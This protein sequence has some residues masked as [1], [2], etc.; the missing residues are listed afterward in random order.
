MSYAPEHFVHLSFQIVV[1]KID[2]RKPE[3]FVQYQDGHIDPEICALLEGDGK[4]FLEWV[5]DLVYN[6]VDRSL[7][8][9][10]VESGI[11]ATLADNF[12]TKIQENRDIINHVQ[13]VMLK[14]EFTHPN[15]HRVPSVTWEEHYKTLTPNVQAVFDRIFAQESLNDQI[16]KAYQEWN[17]EYISGLE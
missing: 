17:E 11:A 2:G 6:K 4:E 3:A 7:M 16:A 14:R 1:L 15:F 13:Y 12:L 5:T 8:G 9:A 10:G